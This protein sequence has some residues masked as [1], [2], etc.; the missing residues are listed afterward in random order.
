MFQGWLFIS[1]SSLLRFEGCA[2]GVGSTVKTI[3]MSS[4][5]V[6]PQR[7]YEFTDLRNIT[8]GRHNVISVV[9]F[10]KPPQKTRGSGFSMFVSISDPSLKG[11]KFSVTVISNNIEKLPPVTSLLSNSRP[12][13]FGFRYVPQATL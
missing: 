2:G 3:K 10:F 12:F 7:Q 6:L 13:T 9:K 11:D 5:D 1:R 4:S 8:E